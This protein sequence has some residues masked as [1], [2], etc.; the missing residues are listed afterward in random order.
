[1][2]KTFEIKMNDGT[3][4]TVEGVIVNDIWGIDKR[5]DKCFYLTHIPT[6]TL[7]TNGKTQKVLKEFVNG[8]DVIDETDL[9]KIANEVVK[10]WNTRWWKG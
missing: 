1:M 7:I 9:Q 8:Q 3:T 4:K 5:E 10:F 6:G 2:A